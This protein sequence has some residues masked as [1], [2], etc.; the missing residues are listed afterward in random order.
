MLSPRGRLGAN[1]VVINTKYNNKTQQNT[2]ISVNFF[3]PPKY[4]IV[5][6]LHVKFTYHRQM[7]LDC[8][9]NKHDYR[10]Q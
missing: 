9:Q 2:C 3:K 10:Y 4:M 1:Q 6:G 7:D 8:K 5:L